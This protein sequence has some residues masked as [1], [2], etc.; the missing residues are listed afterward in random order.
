MSALADLHLLRP[1]WLLALLPALLL[2][3]ILWR[4]RGEVAWRKVIAPH[5]LQHLFAGSGAPENRLRPM[6]LLGAFWLVGVIA[7]A[8]PTWQRE[9]APFAE[10][11]APLV[12][13][14]SLGESMLA[15]D[16]QPSRLERAVH[17]IRDLLA[18]RPGARTAL[19][20]YAGSA[21]LVMP[22]TADARLVEEFAAELSPEL[23][24]RPGNAPAEAL[25]LATQVLQQADVGGGNILL[26]TDALQPDAVAALLPGVRAEVLAVAAPP[27][28]PAPISGPPAPP[29]DRATLG[30]AARA[31]DGGLV[32]VSVDDSDV[33]T[34]ARRLERRLAGSSNAGEGERWR[35]GGH[36]LLFPLAIIVLLWFRRGWAV[37]W[38][39]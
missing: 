21:H 36:Y 23:M 32:E 37:R 35:D 26:I 33:Q 24:P 10:Q 4:R 14:L 3:W 39:G 15:E 9:P 17:K 5:L 38:Q 7:A 8:G 18:L 25:T 31:L 29:L 2:V 28:S 30:A 11:R 22:F 16:I 12:I 20:A 1:L 6:H 27:G 34:L 13:V 19:V